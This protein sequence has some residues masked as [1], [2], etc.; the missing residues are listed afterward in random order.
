MR[1]T[2]TKSLNGN[3]KTLA[4]LWQKLEMSLAMMPLW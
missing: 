3:V 1:S 4:A 2:L